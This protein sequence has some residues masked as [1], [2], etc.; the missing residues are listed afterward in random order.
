MSQKRYDRSGCGLV[1][2]GGLR[3]LHD[4]APVAGQQHALRIKDREVILNRLACLQCHEGSHFKR[5][6]NPLMLQRGYEI[7]SCKAIVLDHEF[8]AVPQRPATAVSAGPR[9]G[10][11]IQWRGRRPNDLRAAARQR[12]RHAAVGIEGALGM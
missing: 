1:V 6:R 3:L 11:G 8:P 4:N 9:E 2:T 10:V 12:A 5:Q 7:T